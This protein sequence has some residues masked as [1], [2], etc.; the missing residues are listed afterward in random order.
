MQLL[1]SAF[2][3]ILAALPLVVLAGIALVGDMI[4]E[5]GRGA[6]L[7]Y[8]AVLLGF[9]SGT[10]AAGPEAEAFHII[11]GAGVIV[12]VVALFFGGSAGLTILA[13]GYGILT[14]VVLFKPAAGLPW[15]L[16]AIAGTACLSVAVRYRLS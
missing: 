11:G 15:P 14:T 1:G 16:L 7:A 2:A 10:I 9:F 5:W 6:L 3:F 8:G 4:G 13:V 12:A